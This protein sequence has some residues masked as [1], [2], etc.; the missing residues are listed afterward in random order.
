MTGMMPG[1]CRGPPQAVVPAG[2]G[3]HRLWSPDGP[4][5]PWS[6]A[7]RGPPL[8]AAPAVWV[9]T[10]SPGQ[11]QVLLRVPCVPALSTS[12][13]HFPLAQKVEMLPCTRL[14]DGRTCGSATALRSGWPSGQ[15]EVAVPYQSWQSSS[16]EEELGKGLRLPCPLCLTAPSRSP[17]PEACMLQPSW[18][19]C[20]GCHPFLVWALG[21]CPPHWS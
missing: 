3:P 8:A 9:L 20:L 14:P 2:R 7:G 13:A 11:C 5:R 1:T 12:A 16:E 6:P 17:S 10:A 15:P 21:N 18:G 4:R 19:V